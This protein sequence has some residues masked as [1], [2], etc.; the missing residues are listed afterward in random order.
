[1]QCEQ[2]RG[3]LSA[4][5]DGELGADEHRAVSAHVA[6]CT[7]C[8]AIQT[9][10]RRTAR[11]LKTQ[12]RV[13]PSRGLP[14]RIQQALADADEGTRANEVVTSAQATA[15][16][17]ITASRRSLMARTAA[18]AAACLLTAGATWWAIDGGAQSSRVERDLLNAHI[19]SLLQDSPVQ[20]ASSDQHTVKPWFAGRTDFAPEVRD[21]ASEGFP[22]V[23]GRLD[24]AVDRRI[25]AIVYKR[26]LHTINVFMWPAATGAEY[27]PTLVVRN[28]YNL[29][30]WSRNGVTYWAVSDLN[31][32]ELRELQRLL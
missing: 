1:M 27:Q 11:A 2:A 4:L 23:G 19:R 3:L 22:L 15:A 7:A 28:G 29:L 9:D 13:A 24:Y 26:R 6:T 18:L 25:G 10:Y 20:V 16:P 14:A 30:S 17:L 8:D 12:G 5:I 21:L 31:A 32:G